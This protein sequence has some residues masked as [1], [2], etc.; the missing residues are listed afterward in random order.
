V[1]PP[2]LPYLFDQG[3][4]DA[5]LAY[6][7]NSAFYVISVRRLTVLLAASSAPNLAIKHLPFASGSGL[8]AA[9]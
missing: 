4:R 6:P 3:L 8:I 7:E 1:Q 5:W 9:Y 2:H